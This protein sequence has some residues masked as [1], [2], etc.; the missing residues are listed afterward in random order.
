MAEKFSAIH[1]FRQAPNELLNIYFHRKGLLLDLNMASMGETDIDPIVR[2]WEELP[3]QTR[4]ATEEDF[5]YVHFLSNAHGIESILQ[6]ARFHEEDLTPNFGEMEGFHEKAFW[7]L[8]ERP[9]Y[10][11]NALRFRQADEMPKRYWRSRDDVPEVSPRDDKVGC[12]DLSRVIKS[13]FRTK[14]ARGHNCYVECLRRESRYYFF[15]YPEDHSRTMIEYEGEASLQRRLHRPVFQIVFV[16]DPTA[17]GL[18][19]FHEGR[20]SEVRDLE[21]LFTHEV[22]QS[23]LPN[24]G[25]NP[26]TYELNPLKYRDF[27]FKYDPMSGIADVKVRSLRFALIGGAAPRITIEVDPKKGHEVLYDLLEKVLSNL[28][29]GSEQVPLSLINVTRVGITAYFMPSQRR[30][31]PSRT[32][33][34][35]CPDSCD[36]DNEGRDQVLLRML[37][38]S[39]IEPKRPKEAD[40][41]PPAAS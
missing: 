13:Y 21:Q 33:Y 1:F 29:P 18:S 38:D 35:A 3:S 19:T 17:G 7:T 20:T 37:V 30:K 27:Q 32:F 9:T 11:E 24:P 12:E 16:F 10:F 36:L 4:A 15:A 2:A 22:L 25:R 28:V 23:S 31:R 39:G 5:G 14:Q 26:S 8:L 41:E 34:V 40:I 6:E